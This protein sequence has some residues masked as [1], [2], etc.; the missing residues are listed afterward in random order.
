MN[1]KMLWIVMA[2]GLVS[3]AGCHKAESPSEVQ[4]D[5]AEANQD[6]S[7]AE[8][9]AE[10]KKADSAADVAVAQAEGAHKVAIEKCEAMSG[11]AQK[12][13]KDKADADLDAAKANAKAMEA[14]HQQ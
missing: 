9:K 10:E 7:Q 2:A 12:A 11:K 8:Q 3:L 4:H 13:C 14:A 1:T 5:V 6:V